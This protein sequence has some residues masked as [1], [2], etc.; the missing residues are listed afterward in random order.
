MPEHFQRQL[1]PKVKKSLQDHPAVYINGPRQAG[2]STMVQDIAA[3]T[4][5]DYLTFDD[6]NILAAA[7]SDPDSFL[8]SFSKQTILDE[9]Q[10]LPELFRPL[11]QVIDELRQEGNANG[12]FTLTGSANVLALP[13]LSDALVGRMGIQTLYPLSV[14][15]VINKPST[16]LSG[17]FDGELAYEE[18]D[19]EFDLIEVMQQATFPELARDT[20]IDRSEWFD[21]YITTILQRDVRNIMDV[22]KLAELPKILKLLAARSGG[23]LNDADLARDAGFNHMTYRRYRS[24]LQ[25][26]YL[27]NLIPAW[28]RNLSKR[29]VKAPKVF[30]LDTMLLCHLLGVDI[31]SLQQHNPGL[32]GNVLENFIASEL[33]KQLA[34]SRLGDLYHF[35]TVDNKEIDFIIE[36]RNGDLLAIEVKSRKQVSEK[37][38]ASIKYLQ[39]EVDE[40]LAKGI[41]LYA[42]NKV[43]S[44]GKNLYA[45]P[46]SQLF[47]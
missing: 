43:L 20:D 39:S 10:M 36:H 13:E 25:Q 22:E 19:E 5:A 29:L 40:K 23:L 18:L 28:S 6:P 47:K 12:R 44:F 41:V 8:R 9:V 26:V 35:R 1:M 16:F 37:D 34:I 7:T 4:G 33:Q 17:M 11:K 42:G 32:F 46:M 15:E 38:F 3:E 31:G 24:L 45:V 2:K 27:T 30:M 14:N 21:S